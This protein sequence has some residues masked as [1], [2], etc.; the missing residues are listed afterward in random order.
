[1][2]NEIEK[3]RK[4]VVVSWFN[5]LSLCLRGGPE[6]NSKRLTVNSWFKATHLSQRPATHQAAALYVSHPHTAILFAAYVT[7]FTVT[8]NGL[9]S[10]NAATSSRDVHT[11]AEEQWSSRPYKRGTA[12]HVTVTGSSACPTSLSN[13]PNYVPHSASKR[14]ISSSSTQCKRNGCL[15]TSRD[16]KESCRHLHYFKYILPL[17]TNPGQ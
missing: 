6:E 11:D 16:L 3:T 10:S 1:M 9:P 8:C 15:S 14:A 2:I 12:P 7:H 17:L 4:E 13:P 5:A